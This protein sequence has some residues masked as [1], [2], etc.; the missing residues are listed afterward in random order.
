M[1]TFK[2]IFLFAGILFMTNGTVK[3]Q[4]T[5]PGG[6]FNTFSEVVSYLQG[7]SSFTQDVI[8]EVMP[9]TYNEQI[10][11]P[12]LPANTSFK[13]IFQKKLGETGEV[14]V[15]YA[16]SGS[17]GNYVIKIEGAHYQFENIHFQNTSSETENKG[18]V[19][20]FLNTSNYNDDNWFK[21]CK[22]TGLTL[23]NS[24]NFYAQNF[25]VIGYSDNYYISNTQFENDTIVGG[26]NG[27]YLEHFA[28]RSYNIGIKNCIIK[29]F[30]STGIFMN[31][32]GSVII[33]GNKIITSSGDNLNMVSGIVLMS[34][35]GTFTV[36][37]NK[38]D[39]SSQTYKTCIDISDINT[40][41]SC[42]VLNN[43]LTIRGA[44]TSYQSTGISLGAYID[45]LSPDIL[46]NS[47]HVQD[48]NNLSAAVSIDPSASGIRS[49]NNLFINTG[50]GNALILDNQ[51]QLQ[52]SGNNVYYTPS[53]NN[54]ID[55]LGYTSLHDW[56]FIDIQNIFEA[57]S[58]YAFPVF[59]APDDLHILSQEYT[60][61]E[62]RA[63][64]NWNGSVNYIDFD[65]NARD[66]SF[67]DIG[68][69][70]GMFSLLWVG[71]ILDNT[72]WHGDLFVKDTV[73]VYYFPLFKSGNLTI[74]PNTKIKFLTDAKL[75][76]AGTINATGTKDALITFTA[77]D[78]LQSWAGIDHVTNEISYYK[79]CKFEYSS[80][81]L[82]GVF[83]FSNSSNTKI[84]HSAFYKNTATQYGGAIYS[85]DSYPTINANMF[86][87]NSAT[88]G[89]AIYHTG[90]E[91][92]ILNN[93]FYDNSA[94]NSGGAVVIN[95]TSSAGRIYNN[96]FY[97]N[98][99][100]NTQGND[101]YLNN[102]NVPITNCIF[103]NDEINNR[104]Y[105]INGLGNS[106][107]NCIIKGGAAGTNLSSPTLIPCTDP[108]F[109]APLNLN[110]SLQP[111]SDA[112]NTGTYY[113]NAEFDLDFTGENRIYEYSFGGQIDIGAY[114][115]QAPK[116]VADAGADISACNS[117]Q[118]PIFPDPFPYFGN[119]TTNSPG[120]T[121]SGIDYF[122]EVHNIP[123]G[124]TEFYWTVTN[125]IV[126]DT[127][128]LLITN[129]QPYVNAGEDIFMI[130]PDINNNIYPDTI[131]NANPLQG[132]QTGNWSQLSGNPITI[133]NSSIN[134]PVVSDIT[135]G[136]HLF[137]WTIND[138]GC[139]NSDSIMLIA[140]H[141]FVSVPDDGILD[142]NNP[143]DWDVNSIPGSADSVTVFNCTANVNIPDAK[144]DRLIVGNGGNLNFEGTA[145][146]PVNFSCRTI[147]IEQ[148]AKKFKDIKGTANIHI[149]ANSTVNIGSGYLSKSMST[150][151][152][153][154][155]I[156]G[157]GSVFVNTNI[158]KAGEA[159]LNIGNGSIIFIEQNAEKGVGDAGFHIGDGGFVFMEQN[160]EKNK[161]TVKSAGNSD[162]YVGTGGYVFM[163]QNAEKG[164]GGFL[165]LSPGRTMF[166]EQSI[167]KS[168]TGGAHI[169]LYGGTIFIE[170]NAEKNNKNSQ[171]YGLYLGQGGT[172]FIEQNA[173]K[174]LSDPMLIVPQAVING[175]QIKVGNA[176][177]SAT[178][179]F[180]F[181]NLFIEQNTVNNSLDTA[182]I[183]YP[184]G[185]FILSDSSYLNLP[186]IY[187]GKGNIVEF[188]EGTTINMS[189]TLLEQVMLNVDE[190]ASFIDYNP[191]TTYYGKRSHIFYGDKE[192]LYSPIIKN[193]D[194]FNFYQNTEI[195]DWDE[196]TLNWIPLTDADILY[197]GKGYLFNSQILDTLASFYG[198][199]NQGDINVPLTVL[200]A[201][202]FNMQGWNFLGNPYPSY[203]DL[204]NINIP[205]EIN[206]NFYF[207]SPENPVVKIY[208]QGGININGADQFT[209]PSEVF[210]VKA[211]ADAN[212]TFSN[213]A[214]VHFPQS[215]S[216]KTATDYIK[217]KV[218]DAGFSD[219]IALSFNTNATD[220]FDGQYDAVKLMLFD[221]VRPQF[222]SALQDNTQ[223][224]I[225]TF[226]DFND[227][228]TIPLFFTTMQ[229]GSYSLTLTG[230]NF[231]N[232]TSVTLKDLKNNNTQDLIAN[233]VYNFTS[234]SGDNA[235]RFEI[236]F[237]K[238]SAVKNI[239]NNEKIKI[240][241]D[242]RRIFVN[243]NFDN[244][245]IEVYDINGQILMQQNITKGL[246]T[247][248]L[249]LPNA[250]YFVRI[251]SGKNIFNKKI[252]L[253]K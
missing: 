187:I 128:T 103:W 194:V 70:E 90:I 79:F 164:T 12:Y 77:A 58:F 240:F 65:G 8:Y 71:D 207:V 212:F 203:I 50:L 252:I 183:V 154:L 42:S 62:S 142:W 40:T 41:T 102:T 26:S 191:G 213:Y 96:T 180:Q 29:D 108:G 160:A 229:N 37:T 74:L 204:E 206:R 157:G 163:E 140:G 176:T 135:Y 52:S 119:L 155:F 14:F 159:T 210:L 31:N 241:T 66:N 158:A 245:F 150:S 61:V 17:D 190:G 205:F 109:T 148:N 75:I 21:N 82:G 170:Q 124:T 132:I 7:V 80:T 147:F 151:G 216:V 20:T 2:K 18:T 197:P 137:K 54:T 181:R 156:D 120:V 97:K 5:G 106:I 55:M 244:A 4:I 92:A 196:A 162:F 32:M 11:M 169:G 219:E 214:R 105:E 167:V 101:L 130:N 72:F 122:V 161:N 198:Y 15:I 126:S 173:E 225:N 99:A 44:G 134:N 189:N 171:V 95:N 118:Y 127:D 182:L 165:H 98:V 141:S 193:F 238:S 116:L 68:A 136:Q 86:Y 217:L 175:G 251:S 47:I 34:I 89:G 113:T 22:F 81:D 218:A 91:P 117:I 107:N 174:V 114:E 121:I 46:Y 146:V 84:E 202:N 195:S 83:N 129:I 131:F 67:P 38:I 242:G 100:G 233:P 237:G 1:K 73:T 78:T 145:K 215:G 144:C 209:A 201:G 234:E 115:L 112:I 133:S 59:V 200:N 57:S 10:V 56:Q 51:T 93:I 199:Y 36:K 23:S 9:G 248:N 192:E 143:A 249:N 227:S 110:F 94:V 69:D 49:F 224:A 228:K 76:V 208:Q 211:D 177:K 35:D 6:T 223:L 19:L 222:Y 230:M 178:G 239:T 247:F 53:K 104:V 168:E 246:N 33:S 87:K 43:M 3:S 226:A 172:I 221:V 253:I 27:I 236:I 48:G 139:F 16:P 138:N 13:I 184:S 60:V 111:N 28:I 231:T 125:G 45:L 30:T 152:S 85:F 243:N 185:T 24:S 149:G 39:L 186:E 63:D 220:Y 88:E 235:N 179:I 232:G 188:A 250:V 25:S 166:V 153:G 123:P 64:P